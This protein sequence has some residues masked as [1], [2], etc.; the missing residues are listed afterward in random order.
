[1]WII[2]REPVAATAQALI[3]GLA[4]RYGTPRFAAQLTLIS[5]VPGDN[6]T[7]LRQA[8]LI[9]LNGL[10]HQRRVLSPPHRGGGADGH[11]WHCRA[12]GRDL[13]PT[14]RSVRFRA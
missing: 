6:A 3:D 13:R 11:C 10:H 9:E 8:P 14:P 1:M 5:G 7:A 2:P 12:S 4:R